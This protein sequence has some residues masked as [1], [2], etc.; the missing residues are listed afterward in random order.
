VQFHQ[1]S[2]RAA[3]DRYL[4]SPEAR[5]ERAFE[6]AL[7]R[8]H[9]AAA[10]FLVDGY[11]RACEAPTTFAV[12]R[13]FGATETAEGWTPNWRERLTC[14]GCGLNNRQ[15]AVVAAIKS[16]VAARGEGAPPSL[17]ATE[18]ITVLFR[19]LSAHLPGV[20]STGSEYLGP[21]L[22]GGSIHEGVVPGVRHEDVEALSFPDESF[23]F[24][25]SNDVLEHVDAPARGLA[26]LARVL[27]AGGEA[28]ITVPFWLGRERSAR[29]AA[30]VSDQVRLLAEPEYHGNPLSAEG[31]L[32]YHDF[33]WDFVDDL[34]EAGFREVALWFY[35][36]YLYGHLGCPQFF[37][38]GVKGRPGRGRRWRAALARR[39]RR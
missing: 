15:R 5:R 38:R 9:A 34:R 22:P 24:V 30:R 10:D 23:D 8:R 12:D 20:A 21:G 25:V 26:E 7:A 18:Q 2:D 39:A 16:A 4:D 31:S 36:S 27:R 29:R 35:W 32:V 14:A 3:V 37:F 17:Y 19:W 13:R 6:A 11:C 1:L 33:G 28:F